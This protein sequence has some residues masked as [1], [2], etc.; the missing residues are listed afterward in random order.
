MG[1]TTLLSEPFFLFLWAGTPGLARLLGKKGGTR[2]HVLSCLW[3]LL[4]FFVG[5]QEKRCARGHAMNFV[6]QSPEKW[7]KEIYNPIDV[8]PT[9]G[10]IKSQPLRVSWSLQRWCELAG[11]RRQGEERQGPC[12]WLAH[13]NGKILLDS[14]VHAARADYLG[15]LPRSLPTCCHGRYLALSA[16]R[17]T[18]QA[19]LRGSLFCR[20]AFLFI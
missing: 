14:R 20:F 9:K 4:D 6:G 7:P 18:P 3:G 12:A 11:M 15:S 5:F 19:V 8:M 10:S 2:G 17:C 13:S 16:T 1:R